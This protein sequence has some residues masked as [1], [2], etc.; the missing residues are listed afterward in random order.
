[1]SSYQQVDVYVLRNGTREPLC[2]VMVRVYDSEGKVFYA[3]SVT[4]AKGHVGFLLWTGTYTLR[5][6][7]FQV[8]FQQPQVIDVQEGPLGA[9][10]QNA[11]N[12]YA[13]PVDGDVATDP[14]LCR[15]SGYFRDITGAPHRFV[16]IIFI[17]EFAPVLLD[18][19][20]VLSERRMIRTDK[21]GF[22]CIDLIRCAQYSA[23]VE[24]LENQVRSISVPSAPSVN[25]PELLFPTARSVSF[26]PPSPW[27]L[28][29]GSTLVLTPSVLTSSGVI[30]SGN[31]MCNVKYEVEDPSVVC[32]DPLTSST[33][34]IRGV[35][36]G[37]TRLLVTKRDSSVI[38]IPYRPDLE[39]S[40]QIITVT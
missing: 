8:R 37:W 26:D 40:G 2:G 35:R 4:D 28:S 39:G 10:V 30:L 3:D 31:S 29:V 16:D 12:V 14:Y 1:M 38:E 27:I 17:G 22:A 19:A 15:A 33:I 24:G 25:L 21:N 13:E 7:K 32:M 36:R 18:G 11:F 23:T 20:G 9:P 34:R 5:F 6:F